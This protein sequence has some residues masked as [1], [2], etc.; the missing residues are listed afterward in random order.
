M[1]TQYDGDTMTAKIKLLFI[2]CFLTVSILCTAMENPNVGS[3]FR[4]SNAPTHSGQR[5]RFITSPNTNP[6]G[7]ASNDIVTG[8]VG[9]GKHF[10]GV[11]PYGS[12]YYSSVFADNTGSAAVNRFI[13]RSA[14]PT[15]ND[16]NPGQI[17]RYYDPRRTV[18]S[19][20]QLDGQTA[21][22][23]PTVPP[24]GRQ[25]DF[26]IPTTDQYLQQPIQQRPLSSNT[27]ELEQILA[28]QEELRKE[29]REREAKDTEEEETT[30]KQDFF[31]INLVPETED[32]D[33]DQETPLQ[34][35]ETETQLTPEEQV[36]ADIQ[37]EQAEALEEQRSILEKPDES[38]EGQLN[39]ANPKS[40][41]VPDVDTESLSNEG[42]AIL[43]DHETFQS[44]AQEKFAGY[45]D[46]AGSFIREGQFYKAADT[47]ALA[48]VWMPQDARGYM[49]QSFSLFAAGEYMS[50]AYYL[51]RALELNP[52]IAKQKFD[53]TAFVGDRD[54][55]ENRLLE[56]STWQER[57]GS[58]ELAFLLAYISHQDNKP[59]R[60]ADAIEKAKAAMPDNPSVDTLEAIINPESSLN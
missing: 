49:G 4:T 6:Y 45:M 59:I 27:L 9:G 2:I 40:R 29:A 5:Q 43:G 41:L 53:L 57:S 51:S 46:A 13:R 47:Y 20:R 50:S 21:L 15:T 44:L 1:K 10:R 19:L 17:R 48:T 42:K 3:P 11:V 38:E 58:G 26:I 8:N 39:L 28:R 54:T 32:Q 16:R 18:S 35:E 30:D 55:Y 56:M 24:Q 7:Q 12:S 36:W 23:T 14:D 60:A 31:D 52:A 34:E 37:K 22:T 33:Q 25:R